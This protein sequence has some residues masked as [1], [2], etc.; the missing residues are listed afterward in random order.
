MKRR[1]AETQ[2]DP[3]PADVCVCGGAC[4]GGDGDACGCSEG[5]SECD[6]C[7][8]DNNSGDTD[9]FGRP[10]ET[11]TGAKKIAL[12]AV[13]VALAVV[14][15][16]LESLIPAPA[17]VQ[18]LKLGLANIVALVLLIRFRLTDVLVVS[19]MRSVF[20]AFFSGAI[21]SMMFSLAGGILSC[22]IMWL[23][24]RKINL[25]ISIIGI[26]IIGAA[27]HNTAQ[28]FVAMFLMKDMAILRYLP[29]LL[30][31]SVFTGFAI[32]FCAIRISLINRWK[33][34]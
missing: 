7:D 15:S 31:S 30:L 19:I 4:D 34:C 24:Y 2:T 25:N 12:L 5:D 11:I 21:S 29:V 6:S 23:F 17:P 32:G 3:E 8:G 1:M 18:G 26:S 9:L 33:I 10:A 13:M 28:I 20:A 14:L 27:T 22:L 16:L